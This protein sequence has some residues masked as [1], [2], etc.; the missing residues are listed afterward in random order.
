MMLFNAILKK[1]TKKVGGFKK[2]LYLCTMIRLKAKHI[3]KLHPTKMP[4]I[5]D[6]GCANP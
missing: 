5:L 1:S 2:K 3:R 4:L 6:N